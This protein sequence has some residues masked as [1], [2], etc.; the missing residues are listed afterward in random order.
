MHDTDNQGRFTIKDVPFGTYLVMAGKEEAGY[1]DSRL[2]FYS[3]PSVPTCNLVFPTASVTVALSPKAGLL[4]VSTTDA[5]NGKKIESASITLRRVANPNF[6]ITT[7]ALKQ[8]IPV[9]PKVD[10]SLEISAPGY[11]TYCYPDRANP[12]RTAPVH[13]R[14]GEE[15]KLDIQLHPVVSQ[16]NQ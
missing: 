12:A 3:N 1:P 10:V 11:E 5:A 13:L 4:E 6:F 15:L 14:P 16:T 2:A 9:P 7:S 8:Q